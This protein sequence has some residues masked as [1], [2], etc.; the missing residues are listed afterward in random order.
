MAGGGC[1]FDY[2]ICIRAVDG[3]RDMKK[4]KPSAAWNEYCLNRQYSNKCGRVFILTEN[5]PC[6]KCKNK[7]VDKHCTY[8]GGKK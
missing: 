2:R 5:N 1:E 4:Q 6:I 7:W 8:N 3:R